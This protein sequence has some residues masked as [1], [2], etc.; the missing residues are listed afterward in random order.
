MKI[1]TRVFGLGNQTLLT[2][3]AFSSIKLINANDP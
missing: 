3:I 1:E 2:A